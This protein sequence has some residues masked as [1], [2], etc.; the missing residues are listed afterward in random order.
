MENIRETQPH[1]MM[2]LNIKLI[3]PLLLF[4]SALLLTSCDDKKDKPTE[5]KEDPN[6]F[7]HRIPRG[8]TKTSEGLV[9]GYVMFTVPNSS[10]I[11]L[12]NR[13]GEVVHQWKGNY[14]VGILGGY[15]MDDGSLIQCAEDPDYPVFGH[16]GPYGRIQKIS[17]ESK[18]IWD[19]EYANEKEM[20]HHD[21]AVLPNGNILAIAYAAKT[22]ED[23][24]TLG[25]KA[26]MIPKDGL[27]LEK[28][29]EIEP[30]GR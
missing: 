29:I 2:K 28:I 22:H 14:N 21:V 13:K 12:I 3:Y 10:F 7:G 20:V 15:L 17:W 26:E 24:R 19:Y 6:M 30:Q 11:Y 5:N 1:M 18:M 4:I 8:L 9:D 16:G 23:A 27:W 25:R